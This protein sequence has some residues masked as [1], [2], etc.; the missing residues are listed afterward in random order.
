[1]RDRK[2]IGVVF[3]LLCILV[4]A[5]LAACG[6]GGGGG[7]VAPVST[8]LKASFFRTL[9]NAP[10]QSILL[11]RQNGTPIADNPI[12]FDTRVD[13]TGNRL[14][15]QVTTRSTDTVSGRA[16]FALPTGTYPVFISAPA[17]TFNIGGLNDKVTV[18]NGQTT[19]QT[20][21]QTW[22]ITAPVTMK[23]LTIT[24]F[25][26]DASGNLNRGTTLRPLNP[27]VLSTSLTL[28]PGSST[29]Q[30]TTELFKGTYRAVIKAVPLDAGSIAPF[31][32]PASALITAAGGG[33]T[34]TVPTINMTAGGNVL[35]L[36]LLDGLTT[37]IAN[38]VTPY[39]VDVYDKA[40]LLLLGTANTDTLGKVNIATGDIANVVV[41]VTNMTNPLIGGSVEAIKEYTASVGSNAQLHKF[42]VNGS[43]VP[44]AGGALDNA[45]ATM[46]VTAKINPQ[47]GTEFFDKTKA[48]SIFAAVSP[49]G[50]IQDLKLFE[51][52]YTLSAR[53]NKFPDSAKLSI[54]VNGGDLTGQTINVR[55]GGVISGRIQDQSKTDIAGVIVQ[56]TDATTNDLVNSAT[57]SAQGTYSISVPFGT[58]NLFANGAVTRSL[59]VNTDTVTKNLTQFNIQGRLIDSL[60]TGLAGTIL[61]SGG[62]T[63]AGPL[64]TYSI[65][66]MEGENWVRFTPPDTSPSLGFAFEPAVLINANTFTTN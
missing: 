39:K 49:L 2:G 21:Q 28:S 23:S 19:Y 40:S 9:T 20:S 46:S 12:I 8:N 32:T 16:D 61:T 6:G 51:G 56:V 4:T 13:S 57:T 43:V 34:E 36:T 35:S 27:A 31:V 65:K 64:G 5:L 30:F 66:L 37:P 24:I 10:V 53:I 22:N 38:T 50:V 25:Q 59:V 33:A 7:G 44:P 1:M 63:T 60:G 52:T 54:T 45:D 55:S 18:A 42:L 62:L 17:G 58:Y 3:G 41:I 11:K 15:G 48:G 14:A 29:A 26:T 47:L